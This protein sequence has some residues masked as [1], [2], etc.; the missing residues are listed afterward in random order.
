MSAKFIV[1]EGLHEG[2]TLELE[3]GDEW[4][5]GRDPE[6]VDLLVDDTSIAEQQALC[7]KTPE[8]ITMQDL[9][10]AAT[11]VKVNGELAKEPLLLHSEDT[12]QMGE[13]LFRFIDKSGTECKDRVSRQERI[14]QA[15]E[16]T[17]LE[18]TEFPEESL[19]DIH[20]DLGTSGRW[21]LKV[22]AGPNT[23]A[24]IALESGQKYL[25]GTDSGSCDVVFQDVSVSRKHAQV[26]VG[27]DERVLIQDLESRNG[28]LIDG[29]RIEDEEELGSNNVVTVGTT[30]F[31]VYD[32][33]SE[34]AT[35]A[36]PLMPQA[37]GTNDVQSTL[38][39]DEGEV[40]ADDLFGEESVMAPKAKKQKSKEARAGVFSSLFLLVLVLGFFG[41]IGFATT[42]LFSTKE[43]AEEST[44]DPTKEL[45]RV[46]SPY[47][48]VKYSYNSTTGTLLLL[49]HVLT[50]SDHSQ[51]RYDIS[52]PYFG[53]IRR[54]N[55]NIIIDELVWQQTNQILAKNK[56]WQGV[57]VNSANKM[58]GQ[59]ILSGFLETQEQYESLI[60]H[61]NR[62]FPYLD[63]L[64]RRIVVE[65]ALVNQADAMLRDRGFNDI[66]VEIAKGEIILS[67]T[68]S[69]EQTADL[70]KLLAEIRTL[71][72]VKGLKNLIVELE[73]EQA[74]VDLTGQYE[75]TGYSMRGG[76]SLNVVING[77]ILSRGDI[78]DG[79]TVTSIRSNAIFLER[80]GF[81]F[82]IDYKP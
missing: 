80:D 48:G 35:I 28:V 8:G 32:T 9:G 17:I 16:D 12:V 76:V 42:T 56:S 4:V 67:G 1:E 53:F 68:M 23:G 43:V 26:S 3:A 81:K 6:F 25:I 31:V 59:F 24:E 22:I 45:Q 54:L 79:M 13:I 60:A 74:M 50:S 29:D 7:R 71:D 11:S 41:I 77:R 70:E 46:F 62:N 34:S 55:D 44:I 52:G 73:P 36:S 66:S 20:F 51:L 15:S 82:R 14:M 21:I 19:A 38:E 58:P 64:E 39:E 27:R 78:L 2:L 37:P 75:V 33:E 18:E 61:M 47:T 49:G 63:R 69:Y 30:A 57:T 5:L 65:E 40:L 72:G 10:W